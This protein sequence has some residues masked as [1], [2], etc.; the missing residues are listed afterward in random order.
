MVTFIAD[1]IKL[2]QKIIEIDI[3]FSKCKHQYKYLYRWHNLQILCY[4]I[5]CM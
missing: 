3:G 4:I 2:T 5:I 1:N